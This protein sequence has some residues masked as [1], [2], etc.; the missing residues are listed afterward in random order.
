M[1]DSVRTHIWDPLEGS[2]SANEY[3]KRILDVIGMGR[4]AFLLSFR[5]GSYKTDLKAVEIYL[6]EQ[7]KIIK[8][9]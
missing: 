9:E 1:F 2:C 5:K 3:H 6:E 7:L 4:Y 8:G